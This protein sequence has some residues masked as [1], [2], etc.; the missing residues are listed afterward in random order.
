M[1]D[2]KARFAKVSRIL[3]GHSPMKDDGLDGEV[4]CLLVRKSLEQIALASLVAHKDAY[5]AVHANFAPLASARAAFR[6]S[7]SGSGSCGAPQSR[8]NCVAFG[9][10]AEALFEGYTNPDGTVIMAQAV[11]WRRHRDPNR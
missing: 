8:R 2:S 1:E 10:G 3:L 5:N 6:Y 7:A 4:V 11:N 9:Y